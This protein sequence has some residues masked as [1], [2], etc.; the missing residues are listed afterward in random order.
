M[1]NKQQVPAQVTTWT[2]Q[3]LLHHGA[4]ILRTTTRLD[5]QTALTTVE[6]CH[7]IVYRS[8]FDCRVDGFAFRVY[9]FDGSI[10]PMF[11]RNDTRQ[12]KIPYVT[13]KDP[14]NH[15]KGTIRLLPQSTGAPDA[16]KI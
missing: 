7:P 13:A 2:S 8:V 6:C 1:P 15:K 12:V 14:H 3:C 10:A 16:R 4:I 11:P 9:P 5:Q